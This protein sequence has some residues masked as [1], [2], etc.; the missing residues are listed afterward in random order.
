MRPKLLTLDEVASYLG[1][2]RNALSKRLAPR[3]DLPVYRFPQAGSRFAGTVRVAE[4][5]LE[6]WIERHRDAPAAEAPRP[7]Q[8]TTTRPIGAPLNLPGADRYA[9]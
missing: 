9:H 1:L 4:A 3:G 8:T 6:R 7:A 5:D 2:S